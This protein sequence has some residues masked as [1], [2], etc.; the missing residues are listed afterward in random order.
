[1]WDPDDE[2]VEF[3]FERR[4]Q[5]FPDVRLISRTGGSIVTA[6]GVELK[7]WYLLAKESEPSFRYK[8]TP[9]ACGPLDLLV[10]VPWRLKN[11]LSGSPI[12]HA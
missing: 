5:S 12:I 6:I 1:M 10:I 3:R 4:S 7:G 8:V 11:I 2:W 9:M